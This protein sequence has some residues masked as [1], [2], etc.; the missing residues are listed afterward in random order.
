MPIIAF[1]HE[2]AFLEKPDTCKKGFEEC[3]EYLDD[4]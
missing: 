3:F 1:C 2:C 4:K